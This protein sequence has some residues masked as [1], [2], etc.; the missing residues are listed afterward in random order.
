MK[1]AGAIVGQN[2]Q[3]LIELNKTLQN[4]QRRGRQE[5]AIVEQAERLADKLWEKLAAMYGHKFSSQY[6]ETPDETWVTC[7]RGISG[8]QIADGL[9]ACLTRFPEWP[10]GAVQFR[11]LCFGIVLDKEGNDIGWEHRTAAYK[12]FAPALPIGT[13][14]RKK[15]RET[16]RQ[17]LD[18][19]LN[20]FDGIEEKQKP[21]LTAPCDKCGHDFENIL[22]TCERCGTK[23]SI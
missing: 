11:S 6:G 13:T 17:E 19:I 21:M 16:G 20:M 9:N 18:G 8:R 10:P 7:L 14:E 4:E 23:R 3:C 5:T 1:R 15:R 22:T 12:E 2:P